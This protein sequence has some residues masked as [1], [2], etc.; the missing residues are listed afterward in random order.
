VFETIILPVVL[1]E[2]ETQS[3]IMRIFENRVLTKIFGPNRNE[4]VG[5]STILHNEEQR[6]SDFR[7]RS[8]TDITFIS[9]IY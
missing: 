6:S 3:P 9:T 2:R 4:I 7:K 1:Y 5:G 8:G